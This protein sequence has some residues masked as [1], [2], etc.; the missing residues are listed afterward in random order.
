MLYQD[1]IIPVDCIKFHWVF[2]REWRW[3]LKSLSFSKDL[4][5]DEKSSFF[6]NFSGEIEGYGTM[7]PIEYAF[8]RYEYLRQIEEEEEKKLFL[9][10]LKEN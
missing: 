10:K 8:M 1:S 2:R 9:D 7:W 4:F 6:R 5:W 3:P